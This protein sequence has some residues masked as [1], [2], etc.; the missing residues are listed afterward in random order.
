LQ[1][2]PKVGNTQYDPGKIIHNRKQTTARE[3]FSAI[4]QRLFIK[5]NTI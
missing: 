4:K 3:W 5:K 1:G 2:H